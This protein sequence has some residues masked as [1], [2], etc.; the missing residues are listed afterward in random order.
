M[1]RPALDRRE[2]VTHQRLDACQRGAELV[3][4]ALHQ[5]GKERGQ[6]DLRDQ[7]RALG[8]GTEARERRRL[9]A[10]REPRLRGGD[11]EHAAP[12]VRHRMAHQQRRGLVDLP[13]RPPSTTSPPA[14]KVHRPTAERAPRPAARASDGG[15]SDRPASLDSAVVTASASFV[16]EP[17]PDIGRDRLEH[18]HAGAGHVAEGVAA[19]LGHG[20]RPLAVRALDGELVALARLHHH[21]R[22][23]HRRPEPAEPAWSLPRGV[24]HAHV[25]AR[26][27]LDADRCHASPDAARMCA[28]TQLIA[29]R[30]RG[31]A[32]L[33]TRTVRRPS[34][35]RISS[36]GSRRT[37]EARIEAS[38]TA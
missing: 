22:P 12:L 13:R 15:S 8:L 10:A 25:Q 29:S 14:V 33:S 17:R 36:A 5:R 18:P 16:P 31:P 1:E 11:H 26:G 35:A 27:R 19:P 3:E 2:R 34:S 32:V 38:R 28:R 21:G 23:A 6:Q 7:R 24:E 20:Q 30:S 37:R 4:V 9:R